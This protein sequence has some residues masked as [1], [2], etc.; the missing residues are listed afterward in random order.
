MHSRKEEEEEEGEKEEKEEKEEE[1]DTRLFTKFLQTR[2]MKKINVIRV[3][4]NAVTPVEGTCDANSRMRQ[5][6][7]SVAHVAHVDTHV[8]RTDARAKNQDPVANDSS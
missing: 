3:I 2:E 8:R 1:E 5:N 7:R 4:H 6:Y